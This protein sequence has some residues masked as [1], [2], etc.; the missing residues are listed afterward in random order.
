MSFTLGSCIGPR[1]MAGSCGPS[2][3]RD[4]CQS[5]GVYYQ[6]TGM[7]VGGYIL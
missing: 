1:F 3:G 2:S 6:E 4:G 7:K 5:G